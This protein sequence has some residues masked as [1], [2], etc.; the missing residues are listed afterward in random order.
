MVLMDIDGDG[1]VD[2]V[3]NGFIFFQNGPDAWVRSGYNRISNG[4]ATLD[5]GSGKGPINLL[6]MATFSPYPFVWLENPMEHG[7]NARTD[8]WIPHTIGP[9]YDSTGNAPPAFAT[10]DLNGDSRMD[11][12]TTHSEGD[13]PPL[14]TGE[15]WWWEAPADRRNGTWV[16]HVIDSTF[17]SAHN[18]R[19]AD[20]NGDGAID[21]VTSEQEQA[22][23]RRVSVFYN[24]G[25]GNFL[26]RILSNGSGHNL[27]LGDADGDGSTDILNAGHG[28]FSAPH[29]VEIYR[30][31][32]NI[33]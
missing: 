9:G 30:N 13:N 28:Y 10:A 26:Q 19:V 22:A 2:L 24:D 21:I 1:K 3:T 31:R 20:I 5:I 18:V 23:G 32:K 33:P 12:V 8:M 27:T 4:V 17:T 15:L 16:R 11:V 14:E 7:G 29:P 25:F 6:G